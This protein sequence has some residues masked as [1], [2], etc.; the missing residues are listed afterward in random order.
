M[1]ELGRGR[2]GQQH[3]KKP[4]SP[5][6]RQR[7]GGRCTQNSEG[8][9]TLEKL[10]TSSV[11]KPPAGLYPSRPWKNQLSPVEMVCSTGA[12]PCEN[13]RRC[14]AYSGTVSNPNRRRAFSLNR[15][16]TPSSCGPTKLVPPN[17]VIV[18]WPLAKSVPSEV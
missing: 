2:R 7:D 4:P 18:S 3:L 17:P 11:P 14:K 1:S 5:A 15:A 10:N 13:P 16:V 12:G 6:R 9:S 8:A